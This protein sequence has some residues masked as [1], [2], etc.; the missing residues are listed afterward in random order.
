MS[1]S[2]ELSRLGT[3]GALVQ[4]VDLRKPLADAEFQQLKRALTMHEVIFF[5][6]QF[7][8]ADEQLAL[9]SRFGEVCSSRPMSSCQNWPSHL[10]ISQFNPLP[11]FM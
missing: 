10:R 5:E 7:L 4:G 11:V 6:D 1:P 8:E 2:I 9:A 3:L